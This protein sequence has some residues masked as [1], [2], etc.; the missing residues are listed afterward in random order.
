MSKQDFPIHFR[1]FRHWISYT[2]LIAYGIDQYGD[3]K[4]GVDQGNIFARTKKSILV[5]DFSAR[6]S[7]N[8][9]LN[10]DGFAI[11]ILSGFG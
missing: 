7:S 10:I 9:L 2:C 11:S 6:F 4:A 8:Y 3:R 1:Q 5:F